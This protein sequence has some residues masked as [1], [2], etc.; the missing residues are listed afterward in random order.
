MVTN[1]NNVNDDAQYNQWVAGR[2][3]RDLN[4]KRYQDAKNERL[5]EVNSKAL[6]L[7]H[8]RQ[9]LWLKWI[10]VILLFGDTLAIFTDRG[11]N[12][13]SPMTTAQTFATVLFVLS[14]FFSFPILPACIGACIRDKNERRKFRKRFGY[15]PTE[16]YAT[17]ADLYGPRI[18]WALWIVFFLVTFAFYMHDEFVKMGYLR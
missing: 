4:E 13:V 12:G 9:T 5:D 1:N 6:V 14:F 7:G 17:K 10:S 8:M 3:Q 15:E 2:L 11:V 16:G 18:G